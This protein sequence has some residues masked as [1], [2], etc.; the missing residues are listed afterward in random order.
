MSAANN[1]TGETLAG[2]GVNDVFRSLIDQLKDP[3]LFFDSGRHLSFANK[4]AR[5]MFGKD[6]LGLS[7]SKFASA[8]KL[9]LPDDQ[10][11][12]ALYD[13]VMGSGSPFGAEISFTDKKNKRY[14]GQLSLEKHALKGHEPLLAISLKD[15]EKL[16]AGPLKYYD[17][18][19]LEN[20]NEG[21]VHMDLQG[22]VVFINKKITQITGYGKKEM[23]GKPIWNA[24]KLLNIDKESILNNLQQRAAGQSE[25]HEIKVLDKKGRVKW[26]KVSASPVTDDQGVVTGAMGI[27]TDITEYKMTREENT[28]LLSTIDQINDLIVMTDYHGVPF[29]INRSCRRRMGIGKNEELADILVQRFY[30]EDSLRR[31]QEEV[32]PEVLRTGTWTGEMQFKPRKGKPFLVSQTIMANFDEDGRVAYF[33]T[34]ARDVTEEKK[35]QREIAILARMPDENPSPTIRVDS[36]GV[37]VYANAASHIMLDSWKTKVGKPLPKVWTRIVQKVLH[38][39][40]Y[41]ELETDVGRKVFDLKLVPIP[42][43]DYVNIIASDITHKKRAEQQLMASEQKYR[44]IVEDQTEFI[45]RFL[46]DGTITFANVAYCRYFGFDAERIIGQNIF[47]HLPG[48]KLQDFKER[49]ASLTKENPVVTYD[50]FISG[51]KSRWQLWTDR[52]IFDE[53]GQFMEFQSV[54]QDITQL[55]RAETEVRRQQLYLRQI[56]D[57]LPNMV[58]VKNKHGKYILV[59]KAFSQFVGMPIKEVVGKTDKS[60]KNLKVREEENREAEQEVVERRVVKLTREEDLQNKD[61]GKTHWFHTV[62]APLFSGGNSHLE[63]LGVSTEITELKRAEEALRQQLELKEL[64]SSIST[65]FINLSYF[66]IDDGINDALHEIGEFMGVDRVTIS[67]INDKKEVVPTY[68]WY[69]NGGEPEQPGA[70]QKPMTYNAGLDQLKDK[71]YLYVP[72]TQ[73]LPG[74]S[75]EVK[76]RTKTMG[77]RSFLTLPLQLRNE[78]TGFLSLASLSDTKEWTDDS[79]AL[80]KIITQVFSNTLER[81]NTEQLL[82]FTLEFEN[83]ITIISTNFINIG[84]EKINDELRISMSYIARFFGIDQAYIFQTYPGRRRLRLTHSWKEEGSD[85][86][87]DLLKMVESGRYQWVYRQLRNFGV[88]EV[89]DVDSIPS[90]AGNFKKIMQ[91]SDVSSLVGVPITYRGEFTGVLLLVARNKESFWPEEA[92]PLLKILGQVFANALDRKRTEEYLSETREMYRTLAQNIPNSAVLLFDKDLRYRLVEGASLEEQGYFKEALE[93]KTIR[94]VLS[95]ARV[96]ELEPLYIK[97]LEGEEQIFEREYNKRYYLI[98]ILPV[99]N[100]QGEIYAGMVVSLDITDLKDIQRKLE[101][102]T[103]ELMRSNEDLELFAYAASHDLQEPLRMVSSYV[104]LIQRKL[105]TLEGDVQEYMDYAVDGVKRMQELINDLLEYSRVD[106]RGKPFQSV[107]LNKITTLVQLNLKQLLEETGATVEVADLPRIHADQSQIISLFQNLIENG[108]KFKGDEA[109]HIQIGCEETKG[110]WVFSVKDN[111]IGIEKKFFERIFII[112]QRLNSRKEYGGTGIGLAVC[113]KIV[114]RHQGDIWVESELN[115]GT[116]FYFSIS[117]SLQGHE[118]R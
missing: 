94:D 87:P 59:N 10:T 32:V 101:S 41:R 55:R 107:D 20:M 65:N 114:E 3:V 11:L 39:G 78:M 34:I 13:E 104:H 99:K 89:P 56:I 40:H 69:R 103:K 28:R 35:A 6:V 51:E 1:R 33:G 64:I 24:I 52:A 88:L 19:V 63:V 79:I 44:A 81:K 93:G 85:I 68:Y 47:N 26:L 66:Q 48:E 50:Q 118:P 2:N 76:K 37:I 17:A 7:L 97:A 112:F 27:Y 113:K 46:G 18:R 84:P 71:G 90:R 117:K 9:K 31:H 58:T 14:T 16:H 49:L 12:A 109:P 54:G 67:L 15:V 21:L 77:I 111:G 29:Y 62:R 5:R 96:D 43:Y 91:Q 73:K 72:D 53:H 80:M 86:D 4:K 74:D 36:Q 38:S 23:V 105:G 102:Q 100:D 61:T 22:T 98:H 108:I 8:A 42:E 25:V 92:V 115:K 106:R 30:T 116:T 110:Q 75:K 83:I 57:T 60:I 70:Q 45:I 82:N 95:S